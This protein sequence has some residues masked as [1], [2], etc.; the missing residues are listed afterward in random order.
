MSHSDQLRQ[1]IYQRVAEFTKVAHQRESF[2]PGQTRIHYAG[3]VYD[4]RELIALVD[5]SLDFWL[6]MGKNGAAFEE[7]LPL[8]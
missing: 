6:T 7:A 1:E 3:R 5:A 8:S 4:E 2:V